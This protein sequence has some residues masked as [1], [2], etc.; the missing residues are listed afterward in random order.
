MTGENWRYSA[1]EDT[2][3]AARGLMGRLRPGQEK[4]EIANGEE[5]HEEAV[6]GDGQG[7][8]QGTEVVRAAFTN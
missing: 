8:R 2:V 6:V 5:D 4:L 3:Y 7:I 1:R